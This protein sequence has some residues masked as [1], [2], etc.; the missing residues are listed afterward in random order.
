MHIYTTVPAAVTL[1]LFSTRSNNGTNF[2]LEAIENN[3]YRRQTTD[4][5]HLGHKIVAINVIL[6]RFLAAFT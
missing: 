4:M 5:K 2:G 1:L 3:W 6:C